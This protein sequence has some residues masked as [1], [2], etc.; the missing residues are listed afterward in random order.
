MTKKRFMK[1]RNG[2]TGKTREIVLPARPEKK[3]PT[4]Q[5]PAPTV[6]EGDTGGKNKR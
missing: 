2:L 5:T 1:I 6:Q 4:P 3:A